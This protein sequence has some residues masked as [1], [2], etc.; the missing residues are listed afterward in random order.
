[1][2]QQ[3][4]TFLR[5]RELRRGF[6]L[7]ELLIVLAIIVILM[8]VLLPIAW[9]RYRTSQIDQAGLQIDTFKSALNEYQMHTGTYPTTEQ[10]LQALI[11]RP[12]VTTTMNPMP[13]PDSTQPMPAYQAPQGNQGQLGPNPMGNDPMGMNPMGNNPMGNDPMGMN[14]MGNNPMGMNPMGNNPMGMNPMGNDPMGMNPMGNNPMG[15]NPMGNDPMGMNPMGNDPMGMNPMGNNP[16]G[17][18]PMGNDP[19]GMNP[20]GTG[21]SN[22]S[23]ATQAFRAQQAAAKWRG[24]YLTETVVP[25]DPWGQEYYYEFPTNR[26][27]DGT[28]T[29]I[30]GGPDKKLGTDD[31]VYP[32]N[33]S[34]ADV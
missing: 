18:N 11:T 15:M 10:G 20:I 16:M 31:D 6:T 24:P 25:L 23:A 12:T 5:N 28:P 30:S 26:T 33:Y 22:Y 32:K 27:D 4:E 2:N 29:I 21:T 1:M 17:M 8:A 9:R 7:I 19:M 14:P 3:I 34:P 13:V